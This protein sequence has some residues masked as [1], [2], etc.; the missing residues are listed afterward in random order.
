MCVRYSL[1]VC[2]SLLTF[3]HIQQRFL[4]VPNPSVVTRWSWIISKTWTVGPQIWRTP[5]FWGG[6]LYVPHEEGIR[7]RPV[8]LNIVFSSVHL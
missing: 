2:H 1:I 5:K 3:I 4:F 7:Y 8:R 6:A